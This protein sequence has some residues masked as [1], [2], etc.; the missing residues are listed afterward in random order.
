MTEAMAFVLR[1]AA[2]GCVVGH[3]A[4]R[5]SPWL[6]GLRDRS[7]PFRWPWPELLG[8]IAFAAAA[9]PAG[10]SGTQPAA[11]FVLVG[12][13]L[14]LTVTDAHRKMLP[15]LLTLGG[16]VIGLAFAAGRPEPIEVFLSQWLSLDFIRFPDA[17][18]LWSQGLVLA[19]LGA[20]AGF[21]LL[22]GFRRLLALLTGVDG[23]GGG[24]PKLLAMIGAFLGPHSVV[25]SLLPACAVGALVGIVQRLR[26]GQPHAAFGPALA[27]GG[28][29]TMLAGD[30][31]LSLL[32]RLSLA[33]VN[34]PIGALIAFYAVL[35]A[36]LVGVVLRMRQRAAA[37]NQILEEDYEALERELVDTE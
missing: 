9:V 4:R 23:L 26:T 34:L 14:A 35:I 1:W 25:L 32:W 11:R 5:L 37:Y 22:E 21:G 29:T 16:L 28:L 3:L 33:L 13:L 6:I 27:A 12:L 2:I 7:M 30:A 36:L 17:A 10:F 15:D 20:A 24:D 31:L 8:G 19:L 18:P